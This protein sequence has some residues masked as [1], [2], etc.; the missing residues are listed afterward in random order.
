[1]KQYLGWL[2][3]D[4]VRLWGIV[5]IASAIGLL[6]AYGRERNAGRPPDREW[7]INRLLVMPLLALLAGAG[8]STLGMTLEVTSI[9]AS[10]LS[11]LAY[12]ALGVIS[13][14]FLK[15]VAGDESESLAPVEPMHRPTVTPTPSNND[16][17]RPETAPIAGLRDVYPLEKTT[18]E[19]QAL[20]GQI[21]RK[22]ARARSDK[23]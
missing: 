20:L 1:M 4:S 16:P 17:R 12:E 3:G 2:E 21:D 10:L 23:D 5:A 8:C 9:V 22:T 18:I 13:T 7:L 11:L 15:K 14:R 19:Q 6:G